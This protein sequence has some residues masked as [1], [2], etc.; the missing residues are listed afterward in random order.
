M[1]SII[2]VY[3]ATFEC[4]MFDGRFS[5]RPLPAPPSRHQSPFRSAR[6][7]PISVRRSHSQQVGR[8]FGL[9]GRRPHMPVLALYYSR[10]STAS[11][12]SVQQFEAAIA[13]KLSARSSSSGGGGGT[14][15][16]VTA[17]FAPSSPSGPQDLLSLL[18]S[19]TH[20]VSRA[21]AWARPPFHT[22]L[23][24]C[25][26]P[27]RPR[28]AQAAMRQANDVSALLCSLHTFTRAL[29]MYSTQHSHPLPT[30]SP[31]LSP[32]SSPPQLRPRVLLQPPHQ[33]R[34]RCCRVEK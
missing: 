15:A 12:E 3:R 6:Q 25:S 18:T 31:P 14:P 17:L 34:R 30:S 22:R 23:L 29:F 20:L 26:P 9:P 2:H 19:S 4:R 28:A 8:T 5:R 24:H 27:V 1:N 13:R 10:V 21:P 16:T 11:V 33:S 32:T 7:W